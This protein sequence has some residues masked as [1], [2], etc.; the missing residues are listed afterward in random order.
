[1]PEQ[2]APSFDD[3]IK[4]GQAA[5]Q[6]FLNVWGPQTGTGGSAAKTEE[7]GEKPGN[8]VSGSENNANGAASRVA[9]M[10]ADYY[11]KH[12]ALW[13]SFLGGTDGSVQPPPEA[14]PAKGDRRFSGNDWATSPYFDYI[15]KSYL[16][17]ANFLTEMARSAQL[18]GK[19]KEKLE[20]TTRQF[21]DAMSP[22]NFAATNPEVLKLALESNGNS[23]SEGIRNLLEDFSKGRLSTTRESEFE[24]GRNLAITPGQ[25]IFENE[26]IQLIQYLPTTP[27]VFK[28]PLLMVPPCINKFYVM[29]MTPESSLVKF[30]VDQGHTVFMLSWRNATAEQGTRTWDD[31]LRMGVLDAIDAA[32]DIA[33]ADKINVLGFCVGGTLLGAAL[34]VLAAEGE[35]RVASVTLLAT[36]L[37]FSD[38]GELGI[39]IDEQAVATREASIGKNGLLPGKDLSVAF[40]ALRANDM[41]WSY[42]VN[43]Y[44]K[45]K[46]PEAFDLLYWNGDS[47]NLP[48]PMYC[49]YLRNTYL[50]NNLRIPDKLT[51]LGQPVDLGKVRA[52]NYVLAT[53]EDHIV[54][55]K[56]AYLST[57]LLGG[58]SRF[59]LGASGHIAGVIN[60]ASKNRRSHWVGD[61]LPKDPQAWFGAATELPGTWW[62]DWAEWLAKHGGAKVRARKTPGNKSYTTIEPA[63]G[64]Y[65]KQPMA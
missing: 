37:D 4:A 10:Q 3:L 2:S 21:V 38:P 30:A 7:T 50:E 24:V 12:L 45:G 57:Q 61:K 64:R 53:R 33:R 5:L 51:M 52:P 46:Q 29:D 18:E 65:V 19:S 1:M 20:F 54:P 40:S 42:V 35:D 23:L 47:T 16:L 62:N 49:Y 63:P 31:Y 58:K 22:A 36:M 41:V 11:Q 60:P 28:R 9:T 34:A 59:V 8:A 55:W 14:L 27:N 32:A 43:N 15:R 25:V 56:T 13:Q 39:F 44:L 26:L 6:Q 48:G 17:N